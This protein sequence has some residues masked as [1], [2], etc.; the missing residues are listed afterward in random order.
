[1][2]LFLVKSDSK[3]SSAKNVYLTRISVKLIYLPF[4]FSLTYTFVSDCCTNHCIWIPKFQV[5]LAICFSALTSYVDLQFDTNIISLI[6]ATSIFTDPTD[7]FSF[8]KLTQITNWRTVSWFLMYA[9]KKC[10]SNKHAFRCMS[11][12]K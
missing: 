6:N 2:Q 5:F 1:M 3:F 7:D 10:F 9:L 11:L 4:V 8:L 12:N